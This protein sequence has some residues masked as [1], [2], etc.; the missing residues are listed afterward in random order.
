M[1]RKVNV[2]TT[3]FHGESRKMVSPEQ[4]LQMAT[5]MLDA[6]G[7][8]KPDLICLPEVFWETGVSQR[9]AT[10]S[11][12]EIVFD[13]LSEKARHLNSYIVA[14]AYDRIGPDKFNV[15]WLIDRSGRLAGRYAKYH[16]TI[17]EIRDFGIKP[18]KEIPVFETDFGVIGLA[19]CYDIGWP[20]LWR[21]LGEKGAELVVWIS[22]YD[23][24]F[25]LQAYAWGNLYYVVSSVRTDHSRIIDKTGK[26]L[27]SSSKWT[28]W[29]SKV[30]NLEK[31]VFHI[32]GQYDKLLKILQR[33]GR[34]V[35]I[36]SFSEENIFTLESNSPDWPISKIIQEFGLE[37]FRA[38]HKRAEMIQ[39][40]S[41]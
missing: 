20:S 39:D 16:P 32:D 22:A 3:C 9:P 21:T 11:M 33:F 5:E 18:G 24:G 8:L 40:E 27:A 38:Y 29:A 15:A 41:R 26:I 23:G 17:G 10:D 30:L 31:E 2:I 6:F 13:L 14:G 37:I 34:D 36:E 12:T 19:I 1:A 7:S 35:T 28:G 25:P 4:N